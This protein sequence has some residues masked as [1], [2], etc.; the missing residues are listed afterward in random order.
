[1][2]SSILNL[3]VQVDPL[4]I[5]YRALGASVPYAQTLKMAVRQN[6]V[7]SHAVLFHECSDDYSQAWPEGFA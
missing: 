3:F 5:V 1:M 2:R 6:T 7:Q 4:G